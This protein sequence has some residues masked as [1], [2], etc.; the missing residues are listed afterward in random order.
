MSGSITIG[1]TSGGNRLQGQVQELRIWSSS[2]GDSAFNNHTKAPAAYD[3]NLDAYN[4]LIFRVPLTQ[5]IDHSATSSLSG[6]EPK[7]SGLTASFAGWST[8]T[9]YDSIEETYYYDAIS[10]AAGTFD[11][12]KI[13]IENNELIGNLDP[14]TR[15][16]RSQFDKAPLDSKKL[17]VYFSPQTMINEDIIAQLGFTELDQYI[18][19][20]G[21]GEDKVYPDLKKIARDYWKKYNDKNDINAYVKIFTLFDLSFFRQLEQL[22]PAR[23][24]LLS[25]I[26]IQPN[27]LERNNMFLL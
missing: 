14:N 4:E 18:G 20:P 24:D 19:D 16:E 22:L 17:G 10:L 12:N 27:I 21:K 6:V 8:N 9:P 1:G 5:K 11:D 15:A 3:G 23:A 7:F 26:L 13:R 2:L 25:G